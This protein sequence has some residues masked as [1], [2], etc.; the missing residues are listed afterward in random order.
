MELSEVFKNRRSIRKYR[1]QPVEAEKLQQILEAGRLAPTASNGQNWY[2]VVLRNPRLL[3]QMGEA[4]GSQ[5][6]V[7][8]A[9][10]NLV[11]CGTNNRNMFC[12]QPINPIDCSIALTQMILKAAELGLG[13][14]WL[15]RFDTGK[16]RELLSIPAEDTI[17]AVTP[18]GYADETPDARPRKDLAAFVRYVD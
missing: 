3:N 14:C 4:C 5:A 9:P 8:Q 13:T 16:V 17:V 7:G 10:V 15:G 2:C 11:I 1:N 6:W 12:G 18:L